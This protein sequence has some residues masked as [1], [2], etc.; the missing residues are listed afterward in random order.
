QVGARHRRLAA[1]AAPPPRGLRPEGRAHPPREDSLPLP[2]VNPLPFW[3]PIAKVRALGMKVSHNAPRGRTAWRRARPM[4]TPHNRCERPTRS[5]MTSNAGESTMIR[6]QPK[7]DQVRL[8]FVIDLND[9]SGP[10]SVVGDFNDWTPG[11][12]LLVKRSN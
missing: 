1:E 11:E 10:V 2:R 4:S 9:H 8:T 7:G 3:G 6:R 12:N 5:A